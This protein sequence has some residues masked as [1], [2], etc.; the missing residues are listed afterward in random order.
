MQLWLILILGV[1]AVAVFLSAKIVGDTN[2]SGLLVSK[3]LK[4]Y[5]WGAAAIVGLIIVCF[6]L[7]GCLQQDIFASQGVV[8]QTNILP[9]FEC[10]SDEEICE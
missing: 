3:L 6:R 10:N 1:I 9:V 8:E 5:L 4:I 7:G 2:F